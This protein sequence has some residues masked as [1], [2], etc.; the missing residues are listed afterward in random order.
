MQMEDLAL[1]RQEVVLDVEPVHG[2]EVAPEN[3]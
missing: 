3:G 2:F 1:A